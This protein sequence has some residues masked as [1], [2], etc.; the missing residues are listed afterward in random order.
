MDLPKRSLMMSEKVEISVFLAFSQDLMSV[1]MEEIVCWRFFL[2][3]GEGRMKSEDGKAWGPA[4]DC[5]KFFIVFVGSVQGKLG[6][7]TPR[8]LRSLR[9]TNRRP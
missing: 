3:I 5:Q 4:D 7:I 1:E 2:G 9:P 6:W 8:D